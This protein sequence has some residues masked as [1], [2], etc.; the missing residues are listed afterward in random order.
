MSI[1]IVMVYGGSGFSD[2]LVE[3]FGCCRM[4]GRILRALG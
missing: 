2:E 1:L 3:F 4:V